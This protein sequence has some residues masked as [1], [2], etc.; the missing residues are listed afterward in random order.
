[1][2]V[3]Q[4]TGSCIPI[5]NLKIL[6]P[7]A[8]SALILRGDPAKRISPVMAARASRILAAA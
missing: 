2:H 4:R 3:R 5:Q 7:R 8:E 1:M 6:L